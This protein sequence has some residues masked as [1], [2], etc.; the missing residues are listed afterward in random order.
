MTATQAAALLAV[1]CQ[2]Q[3]CTH[4]RGSHLD[5]TGA[6]GWCGCPSFAGEQIPFGAL[7]CAA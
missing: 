5:G 3:G 4:D 7:E 1:V 2:H 6:C